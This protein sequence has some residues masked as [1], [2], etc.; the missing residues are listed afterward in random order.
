MGCSVVVGAQWGDEGKGKIIDI[1]SEEADIIVRYQGGNNAGHT[2]IIGDKEYTF[3]L[4]PS[5]I[6]HKGKV[7]IIGNGV[8]VDPSA[9]IEEM[10]ELKKMG[11]SFND[12][13]YISENAHVIMPYHKVLDKVIDELRGK[14]KIGVT[15]RGIGMAYIDKAARVGIRMVDLLDE[16]T[17]RAKV[18]INFEEKNYLLEKIYKQEKLE[19]GRVIEEYFI[20]AEKIRKHIINASAYVNKALKE[21][22]NVM[23]EGAQGALLDVDFG[24][25]PYVTSSNPIAAGAATGIG[26]GPTKIDKVIGVVKAYTTRVG[27]GP[28]P[29]EVEEEL[30]NI[31]RNAGPIGEYGRTTGR[32]R[33]IGWLD[34]PL[35]RHSVRINSLD[36]IAITRLD[37][38]DELDKIKVCVKYK[39][40]GKF[41]EDVPALL[42]ILNK[43][44]PIYE[45]FDGWKQDSS[46][47]KKYSDLPANARRYL[48]KISEWLGVPISMISIGP[49]RSQTI[50]IS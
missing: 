12:N 15:G 22:K 25:Y 49:K 14:G 24:T 4:I 1:L 34:I 44:E 48:E 46:Q 39:Y 11:I 40:E 43:C 19:S 41:F 8:V 36:S 38:L 21:N 5:G 35:L 23:F 31:M 27:E 28:F 16:E 50:R 45:E 30:G 18:E 37:I 47:A 9:L 6:L 32:P 33:R 13:F 20:Y 2:V 17:F 29:A 10:T 3:H 26:I 7:C 42:K